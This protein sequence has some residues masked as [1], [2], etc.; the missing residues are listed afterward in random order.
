MNAKC[1]LLANSLSV[2]G[3]H[4]SQQAGCELVA[5]STKVM[6]RLSFTTFTTD[7]IIVMFTKY[8][9]GLVDELVESALDELCVARDVMGELTKQRSKF[10]TLVEHLCAHNMRS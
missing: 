3:L 4:D 7:D 2:H 1:S 10:K 9:S 8:M 6:V 5:D